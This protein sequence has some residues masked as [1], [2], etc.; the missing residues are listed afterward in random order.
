MIH[1]VKIE[2]SK[3]ETMAEQFVQLE[4]DFD[5]ATA[6]AVKESLIRAD[7]ERDFGKDR[8]EDGTY[9]NPIR[10]SSLRCLMGC[11]RHAADR[12]T[13][14]SEKREQT[15]AMQRGCYTEAL[16][17]YSVLLGEFSNGVVEALRRKYPLVKNYERSEEIAKNFL[18]SEFGKSLAAKDLQV[19]I[20]YQYKEVW[21]SMAVD[22]LKPVDDG[23]EVWDMKD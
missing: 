4:L 17:N 8:I 11:L 20:R 6:R 3:Y 16:I 15:P 19:P 22:I 9:T 7:I 23:Y 21:F 12:M 13:T 1:S 18:A 14:V 5:G 2:K 10:P